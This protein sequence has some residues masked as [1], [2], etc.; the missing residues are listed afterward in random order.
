MMMWLHCLRTPSN[1]WRK[2]GYSFKSSRVASDLSS[3][4]I[5]LMVVVVYMFP[6]REGNHR[7]YRIDLY[8]Y[9]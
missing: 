8:Y 6:H 1:P 2:K 7:G 3:L 9:E 4:A 5:S